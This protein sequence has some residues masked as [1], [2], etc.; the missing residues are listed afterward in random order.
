MLHRMTTCVLGATLAA[1]CFLGLQGCN[2]DGGPDIAKAQESAADL[3]RMFEEQKSIAEAERVRAAAAAKQAEAERAA[4]QTDE[5]K[6]KA[7]KALEEAQRAD[8]R[9][10]A[11]ENVADKALDTLTKAQDLIKKATTPEGTLDEGKLVAGGM[12]F[13]PPPWNGLA[14]LVGVGVTFALQEVRRR[15]AEAKARTNEEAAVSIINGISAAVAHVPGFR[16]KMAEAKPVLFAER[17][18]K[19]DALVAKHSLAKMPKAV[20]A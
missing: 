9:A 5:E 19:A 20:T 4:A 17:T 7:D 1:A 6:A 12:E 18:E 8:D 15:R 3:H 11:A 16:E 14:G 10:K 2:A 13:L